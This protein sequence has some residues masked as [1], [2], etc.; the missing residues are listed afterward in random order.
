MKSRP[1]RF[2]SLALF[3][4]GVGISFPVQTWML[5]GR[6]DLL[7]PVNW[8]VMGLCLVSA[9][10]ALRAS[11]WLFASLPLLTWLVIYNNWLVGRFSQTFAVGY[12]M[13]LTIGASVAFV[14]ALA[15]L[16]DRPVLQ[17][18]LHPEHR[19][20]QTARRARRSVAVRLR[21]PTSGDFYVETFDLSEGGAFIPVKQAGPGEL[22]PAPTPQLRPRS[23]T[24]RKL[25]RPQTP[26]LGKFVEELPVGAQCY[27]CLPLENMNF[28]Q[29]RAE[30][31]RTTAGQG[32]YPAGVGIRFLGL[33]HRDR[34]QIQSFLESTEGTS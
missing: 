1:K 11:S 13:A 10:L 33:N 32:E 22:A 28:I 34:R 9:M 4:T 31:V 6:P 14:A 2:L 19:W 12:P 30:V 17:A 7:T 15:G 18:L 23:A 27:V 26:S 8:M 20:W 25:E 3:L 24:T 5:F 16:V 21:T 29:C